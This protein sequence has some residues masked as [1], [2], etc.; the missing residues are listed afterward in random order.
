MTGRPRAPPRHAPGT[1]AGNER[2]T[3]VCRVCEHAAA[4]RPAAV[5]SVGRVAA[6][7]WVVRD[8]FRASQVGGG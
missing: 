7:C 6:R 1:T 8:L 4:A 5:C 2:H 3:A